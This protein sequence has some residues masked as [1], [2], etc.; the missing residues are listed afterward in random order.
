M[1]TPFRLSPKR[2]IAWTYFGQ[3]QSIF[4]GIGSEMND[5]RP[6]TPGDSA[7]T[8][9]RK[10]SAKHQ[11]LYSTVYHQEKAISIDVLRDINYNWSSSVE[12]KL[13][14]ERVHEVMTELLQYATRY[15]GLLNIFV[16]EST[17]WWF[18]PSRL[19][20]I[21]IWKDYD[22]VR[23]LIRQLPSLC[24]PKKKIYQTIVSSFLHEMAKNKKRRAL[25]I[26]SDFLWL[27]T[28]D[29]HRLQQMK[30]EHALMLFRLPIDLQ[31]GQ[32]YDVTSLPE[33]MFSQVK[34]LEIIEL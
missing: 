22:Q 9:N 8:I 25:V 24:K 30:K 31:L 11:E 23:T 4:S 1:K 19:K 18:G 26:F 16:P 21:T 27:E 15:G 14:S 6:Y 34:W 12:K 20:K 3:F 17:L 29:M 5:V 10:T 33:D 7:K 32:N 2:P 28:P 13:Q